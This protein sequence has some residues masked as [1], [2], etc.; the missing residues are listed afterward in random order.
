MEK[1]KSLDE[2]NEYVSTFTN[3]DVNALLDPEE[4][5]KFIDSFSDALFSYN[6]D[7]PITL[8]D[9]VSTVFS[10]FANVY[11]QNSELYNLLE[12]LA[13]TILN[14]IIPYYETDLLKTIDSNHP[15]N[16]NMLEMLYFLFTPP[17]DKYEELF[18]KMYDKDNNCVKYYKGTKEEYYKKKLEFHQP[19]NEVFYSLLRSGLTRNDKKK[20]LTIYGHLFEKAFS[21]GYSIEEMQNQIAYDKKMANYAYL[22]GLKIM[23]DKDHDA[24]MKGFID[25]HDYTC[26]VART[27]IFNNDINH[28]FFNE[29]YGML[30]DKDK[31]ILIS[32]PDIED[33][34]PIFLPLLDDLYERKVIN[35]SEYDKAFIRRVEKH[36]ES[37]SI[38]KGTSI[39]KSIVNFMSDDNYPVDLDF[40]KELNDF[41]KDKKESVLAPIYN[42]AFY[43]IID[44]NPEYIDMYIGYDFEIYKKIIQKGIDFNKFLLI[45]VL[46]NNIGLSSD[47][48]NLIFEQLNVKP[49][50]YVALKHYTGDRVKLIQSMGKV[51]SFL[52]EIGIN[53]E[54]FIQYAFASSYNWLDHI[55]EIYDTGK[56]PEFIKI[57][58]LF[59]SRFY[60]TEEQSIGLASIKGLIET[61]KNYQKY[62]EL[63]ISLTND[64]LTDKDIDDLKR[65]FEF[66]DTIESKQG[67]R[68]KSKDELED[69]EKQII[70][71]YQRRLSLV[72][73]YSDMERLKSILC[74]LLFNMDYITARDTLAQYGCVMDF[75]QLIFN[76]RH[77]TEIC[78]EILNIMPY[79]SMIEDVLDCYD[80]DLLKSIVRQILEDK[81]AYQMSKESNMF[82]RKYTEKMNLLYGK[83]MN[84]NLTNLDNL[85]DELIDKERTE[86]YGVK[87]YDLSR[88]KYCILAHCVSFTEDVESLINGRAS[89][90]KLVI[91]LTPIS[92]RGLRTFHHTSGNQLMLCGCSF[93]P[94]SLIKSGVSNLGSNGQV[95]RFSYEVNMRYGGVS[96]R[97]VLETSSAPKGDNSEVLALREGLKLPYVG[98]NKDR[99]PSMLEIETAKKFGSYLIRVQEFDTSIYDPQD[100]I[101]KPKDTRNYQRDDSVSVNPVVE[102]FKSLLRQNQEKRARR[103]A[104]FTDSH[105]IYEATLAVLEDARRRGITEIYSLGDNIGTG[106]NPADVMHLLEIYGVKSLKGNHE[107]YAL[108]GLDGLKEHFGSKETGQSNDFAYEEAERNSTWSRGKLTPE[109]IERIK[110]FPEDVIIEIGGEK[111]LLSHYIRDYNTGKMKPIPAGV[112]S[113]FQGHIHQKSDEG[114]IHTIRAAGLYSENSE[115]SYVILT[116][117]E[118]GGFTIEERKIPYD[119]RSTHFDVL[120]SDMSDKRKIDGWIKGGEENEQK[121]YRT[122]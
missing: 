10:P 8:D 21:C 96:Q 20:Y 110:S 6:I 102:H 88:S 79:V 116:E 54:L 108:G 53:R 44:N 99:E 95:K 33:I 91:S 119:K 46:V 34:D 27:F 51:D 82:F 28:P 36:P 104:L 25:D 93:P 66:P 2:L 74:E 101:E 17:S 122:I 60:H 83:E 98:F 115:A 59:F 75:R 92:N 57:K 13:T 73:G 22:Q 81:E 87:V 32:L 97:G 31:K 50:D 63:C 39:P 19:L 64:N 7:W 118:D 67:E 23:Y 68:I 94:E 72:K 47:D 85:P 105:G 106:P 41:F 29:L 42:T 70:S 103:I 18:L 11:D 40:I 37:F 77:N 100:I 78:K 121:R 45:D 61:L 3:Y 86:K 89:G 58:N 62:P 80:M 113:V 109:Q 5:K 30:T 49:F 90:D 69:V 55:L 48:T 26:V 43:R 52:H 56:I 9:Y 111:V 24:V 65:L 4:Q 84:A 1:L 107:I 16:E 76:N 38:Y 71:N 35:E 120:E 117:K 12:E 14:G 112:S 114:I 15:I